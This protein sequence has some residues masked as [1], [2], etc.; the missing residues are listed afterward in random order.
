MIFAIGTHE[1]IE[2]THSV[3]EW[4]PQIC[5]ESIRFVYRNTTKT[6]RVDAFSPS[7]A[8][9]AGGPIILLTPK[10]RS[11]T[12]EFRTKKVRVQTKCSS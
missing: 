4:N 5:M 7:F 12:I 6:H 8:S 9:P 3:S 10:S 1:V 2:N 11:G